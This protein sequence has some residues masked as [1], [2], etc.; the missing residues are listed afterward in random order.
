MLLPVVVDVTGSSKT[1]FG[2]GL[3]WFPVVAAIIS[4]KGKKI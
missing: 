2:K 3:V 1:G 4:R